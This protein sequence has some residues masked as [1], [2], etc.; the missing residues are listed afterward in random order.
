MDKLMKFAF[1]NILVFSFFISKSFA[2]TDSTYK[3]ENRIKIAIR[4]VPD[5][6][7]SIS[8]KQA[9]EIHKKEQAD[10]GAGLNNAIGFI[11]VRQTHELKFIDINSEYTSNLIN[12]FK[13]IARVFNN[14]LEIEIKNSTTNSVHSLTLIKGQKVTIQPLNKDFFWNLTIQYLVNNPK[15]FLVFESRKALK[16]KTN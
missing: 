12:G 8:P 11:D 7:A 6:D 1:A 4:T 9:F 15:S 10:S 2:Q 14:D 13:I 5:F 3:I 16:Q